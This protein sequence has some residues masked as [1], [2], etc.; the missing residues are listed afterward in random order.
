MNEELIVQLG[1][2]TTTQS[3]MPPYSPL[4][5]SAIASRPIKPSVNATEDRRPLVNV[6]RVL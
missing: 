3:S 1:E 2:L 4:T 6:G 5:I